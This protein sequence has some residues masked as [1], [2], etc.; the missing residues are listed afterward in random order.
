[1]MSDSVLLWWIMLC[2]VGTLNII[3][4]S[5]SARALWIR[6]GTLSA[7]EDTLRKR[8]LFL[9]AVYVLGCA[10]RSAFPV[11]DVPRTVLVDSFLSSVA[12]GRT[13]ATIAE[14]SFVAQW[15]LLLRESARAT[16][17]LAGNISSIALVPLIVIAECCSWYSVLTA[18]N[19][20][21]TVEESI[22]ALAAAAL[23]L[24]LVLIW[25][26][27][28]PQRRPA[29]AASCIAAAAYL[30]FMVVVDVPMYASRWMTDQANGR[31]YLT[32][33]AG[34]KDAATRWTVSYRWQDWHTEVVWMALYF[35]VCVWI[36]ISLVHVPV[37]G[38]R[39]PTLDRKRPASRGSLLTASYAASESPVS[40]R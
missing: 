5:L 11:F 26:R 32:L 17:S 38:S 39:T 13:V 12:V 37:P 36:S 28:A 33:A 1:M 21:H 15:A 27:C 40:M 6:L 9:S 8:L 35:S 25:P 19:L 29:L 4:W 22:W 30:C 31:H 18:S 16:G 34:L 3:I 20:G 10:Y 24:N 7:R 14:L 23:V 2:A